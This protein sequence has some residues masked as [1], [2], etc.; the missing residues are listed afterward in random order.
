MAGY[1]NTVRASVDVLKPVSM[2]SY[3]FCAQCNLIY[4]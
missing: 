4:D 2:M 3:Y 1:A